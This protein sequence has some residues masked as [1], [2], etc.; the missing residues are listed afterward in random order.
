MA[1][2]RRRVEEAYRVAR[3][4]YAEP[5]V[6]TEAALERLG[7]VPLSLHCWQG[8]DARGFEN[9][10]ETLAGSG[11]AVTGSHPGRARNA[12][13]LRQD[14]D[15]ALSLIPGRHRV[16]LH[17]MYGEFPGSV[18]RDAIGPEH[19]AGWEEWAKQRGLGL[20]FNATLFAHPKAQAGFTLS[21][22]DDSIRGFWVEHVRRCRE[23]AAH[24]G[25]V[26][27]TPAI[28]NLWIPDGAK[29]AVIDRW[30]RR[31]LLRKSLDEIF[32]G[33]YAVTEMKDS[34][35]SKLW[36]V[37]SEAFVVGSHEFYMGYALSRGIMLCLDTGH[38]HPTE[39]VADKVSAILHFS[40]E[41]LLHVSRG[42]RW[43]S[44]HVVVLDDPL[45]ELMSEVVRAGALDRVHFAL[46]YF[47]ASL[48]RV[49]AWVIGARATLKALLA[50]LLEP[51]PRLRELDAA[52]DSAGK[53]AMLENQKTMPL[54]AVWDYYCQRQSVPLESEWPSEVRRYEA[55]VLNGRGA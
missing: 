50:A 11:L 53:L 25:R 1:E 39:S 17:A 42:V 45:K 20:D 15:K 27:G 26:L 52:G 18:D 30:E 2:S 41:L 6:D 46:D 34:V 35:E 9:R 44:D 31:S 4:R 7:G 51:A 13:E 10:G 8:D 3:E 49:A 5:D 22:A 14:L 21:S 38:F 54:G 19:F 28:H 33:T 48:N 32:A 55:E 12:S 29:D 47:D 40:G 24:M 16:N 43:D 37:G 36:G 23:I